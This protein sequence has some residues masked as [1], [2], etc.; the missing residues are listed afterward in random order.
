MSLI[1]LTDEDS[2]RGLDLLKN[3][4]SIDSI[5]PIGDKYKDLIEELKIFFNDNGINYE[6]IRVPE[7]YQKK[8]CPNASNEPRLIFRGWIGSIDS[9]KWLHL[10]GH[11]DVVPGGPGWTV[12]EPFKPIVIE[13]KVYGRG[14]TDMKGGLVS[15]TLALLALSKIDDKLD[16]FVDAIYVPDEEIGGSCGTGYFVEKLNKKLPSYAIIAEPSTLKHMYIGHKGGIWAKVK[17]YG[18]TAHASTPWLGDNAFLNGVKIVSWLDQNYTKTLLERK[19][20]YE[21]DEPNGNTPT[22][23]IGG[24]AGVPNGKSNQVPGEFYFTIDRRVIVDENI[25]EAEK[26]LLQVI[27][28]AKS[29]CGL[30]DKVEVEVVSKVKPAFVP[31]NNNLSQSIKKTAISLGLEEPKELVCV[32]GLDLRYYTS[33]DITVVSYGPGVP[34]LAHAPNEYVLF[35]DVIKAAEVYANLPFKLFSI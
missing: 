29:Y 23:M 8:R 11:Y 27:N 26:E 16:V 18:K 31:P 24:E 6:V 12:T 4:I 5:S 25:D 10:N 28:E 17:V 3:L 9:D 34:G 7:E 33:K 20:S 22:I 32:G 15:M 13:D 14:S 19:S 1:R 21:Y 35:S 30:T 2:R